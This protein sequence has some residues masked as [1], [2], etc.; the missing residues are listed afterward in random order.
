M[1]RKVVTAIFALSAVLAISALA[2][3]QSSTGKHTGLT[4][5]GF[6][7]P[8]VEGEA[9]YKLVDKLVEP[10]PG[11]TTTDTHFE[12]WSTGHE[13]IAAH[14]GTQFA[15]LNAYNNGT[16][17]QDSTGIQAESVLEFTFAHRGRDGKDTMKLTITDLGADNTL[18]GV[19]DKELFAKE[20][21]TGKDAWKVYT[22]A[23]EPQIKALG[24]TVRFA[25]GAIS[26]SGGN[27]AKGNLLDAANFGIG[28]IIP[29]VTSRTENMGDGIHTFTSAVNWAGY[30]NPICD[31]TGIIYAPTGANSDP[32]VGGKDV[33]KIVAGGKVDGTQRG[34]QFGWAFPISVYQKKIAPDTEYT[35]KAYAVF[36]GETFYSDP[37]TFKTDKAE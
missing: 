32:Q 16:L 5:H 3:A 11:W 19:D 37:R 1:N 20:Y 2:Q 34:C 4:N 26:A 27:L 33:L 24:N 14:Q 30:A 21:T 15:E 35:Y 6:E 18:D 12:I 31:E 7:E 10:I 29:T 9:S 23:T 17:Y 28:V 22:S 25:Y 13:K 8:R 36:A